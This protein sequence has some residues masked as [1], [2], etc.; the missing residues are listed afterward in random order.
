MMSAPAGTPDM[1]LKPNDIVF[2][3]QRLF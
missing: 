3:P 2:V 1:R